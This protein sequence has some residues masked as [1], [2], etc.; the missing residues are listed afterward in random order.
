MH[1]VCSAQA[2]TR[3]S[4]SDMPW[5]M[6]EADSILFCLTESQYCLGSAGAKADFSTHF[7]G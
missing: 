3:S 5:Q 4:H 1:G 2:I 7:F 6:N